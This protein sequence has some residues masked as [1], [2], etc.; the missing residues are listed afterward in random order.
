MKWTWKR[1]NK[2]K[3]NYEK[4]EKK[5]EKKGKFA[6]RIIQLIHIIIY[7]KFIYNKNK[8]GFF[9][10]GTEYKAK[11]REYKSYLNGKM[12]RSAKKKEGRGG[13]GKWVQVMFHIHI[14]GLNIHLS[15]I[16]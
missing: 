6:K 16:E 3:K 7:N 8:S 4:K 2:K 15:S 11:K 5:K 9:R 14:H 12:E 1:K 13:K 10:L